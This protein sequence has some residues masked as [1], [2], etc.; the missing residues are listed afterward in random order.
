[1]KLCQP[2]TD[3][4]QLGHI[5]TFGGHPV[6]CAAGLASLEVIIEDN[7]HGLVQGKASLFRKELAHPAI[8]NIRGDGLLLAVQ[9]SRPEYIHYAI[10]NAPGHGL[11]LDYFLFCD[12]AF[13]IAPPLIISNE[14]I[15]QSCDRIKSLL[16]EAVKNCKEK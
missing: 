15:V 13:R 7:L 8:T 9:L 5:T 2:S 16:D 10:A 11:I 1:M 3:N 14:E 12:N 4:P 6:C